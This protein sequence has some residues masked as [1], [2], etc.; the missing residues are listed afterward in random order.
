[1][2][3]ARSLVVALCL[4]G[5]SVDAWQVAVKPQLNR[6]APRAAVPLLQAAAAAAAGDEDV[7][8]WPEVLQEDGTA[9]I[10][11]KRSMLDTTE[12][13]DAVSYTHLRA[14]ET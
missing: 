6:V 13:F 1:M 8:T 9:P 4:A 10:L 3:Y 12:K 14:H 11:T 5:V 2:L 7:P